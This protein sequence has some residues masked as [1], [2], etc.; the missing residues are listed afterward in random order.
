MTYACDVPFS[1]STFITPSEKQSANLSASPSSHG[2]V[3]VISG[4]SLYDAVA[5][6][7]RNKIFNTIMVE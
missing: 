6:E 2:F 3:I 7:R 5:V 1:V 4:R